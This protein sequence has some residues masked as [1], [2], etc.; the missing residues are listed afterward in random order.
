MKRRESGKGARNR[1]GL[2][3]E[4]G[5]GRERERVSGE[6]DRQAEGERAEW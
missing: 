6:A 5:R 2:W 1:N 4:L 3:G